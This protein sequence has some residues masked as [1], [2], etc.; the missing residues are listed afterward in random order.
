MKDSTLM[1]VPGVW[2]E[3]ESSK[4]NQFGYG[5]Y[6]LIILLD[7]DDVK[8]PYSMYFKN[9]SNASKVFINGELMAE[10][11]RLTDKASEFIPDNQPFQILL[12]DVN[13]K[14]E[15]IIQVANYID[16]RNGGIEGSIL[17]GSYSTLIRELVLVYSLQIIMA[18]V[19]L[20]HGIYSMIVYFMYK[21]RIEV[22]F[23]ALAFFSM[24]IATIAD[25]EKLLYFIL[26]FITYKWWSIITILSYILASLFLVLTFKNVIANSKLIWGFVVICLSYATSIF[27]MPLETTLLNMRLFLLIIFLFPAIVISFTSVKL[28]LS[29]KQGTIFLFLLMLSIGSSSIWGI[30]KNTE[31][32]SI[33]RYPYFSLEIILAVLFFAVYWFQQFFRVSEDNRRFALEME[34]IDKRKDEFL[35][36]TSHELR[37][38][39]HGIIMI[40]QSIVEDGNK[41]L[42]QDTKTSLQLLITVAKRLS[43]LL[44]ELVDLSNIKEKRVRL[45][46]KSVNLA[47]VVAGVL[48]IHRFM[49]E[50]KKIEF[51]HA[52]PEHFPNVRAD[53]NRLTQ[54][55][56]NLLHNALK[57]TEE[58]LIIVSAEVR[59][60]EAVITVK[61][62][63][64]GMDEETLETI[65]QRYEQG[66]TNKAAVAEGLGLGLSI[67]KE[68]V[69]L[70]GG[71]ISVQ[72]KINGGSSFSFTIPLAN[73]KE[74]DSK[75]QTVNPAL[76]YGIASEEVAVATQNEGKA[77]VLVV[78]DDF[79]NLKIMRQ[80]LSEMYD[81][82]TS[83]N[84]KE[85][86]SFLNKGNWDL[87]ITDV[88]M[89]N[90][91][92]Y[93][94]SHKIREHYSITELP[95]LLLTA[96]S[97]PEDVQAGF[98]AGAN[99]YITKPVDKM[100][101]LI[102]V[103]ALTSL[104]N[105]IEERIIMES[106]WL[107]AQIEPHFLYNTLNT[108]AAL[109]DIDSS[110][111][112]ALLHEFGNYLR[113]SF[114]GRN[115]NKLV[116]IQDELE[117]VR[118]Y[119]YIEKERFGSRLKVEWEIKK[120][121]NVQIPPLA[122]Q[123]LVENAI[124]H[125]V[126]K[127]PQGGTVR[128]EAIEE[129]DVVKVSIIDDGVGIAEEKL[130]LLLMN[131][132]E[133]LR[134]IGLVNTDKRLKQLF[135][136]GLDISSSSEGTH[137]T[138]LLP[139]GIQ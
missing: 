41:H 92:G 51:I 65:F 96:R 44:N 106:A 57:F 88:M 73:E 124:K 54:I 85:A 8:Q 84:G 47:S 42:D 121:L 110:K 77:R 107:Q 102:R 33:P 20:L 63:G 80:L 50:G 6:R 71:T 103:Q 87:V 132:K 95:I 127:R 38:P 72:S 122:I 22:L 25:D 105:S 24:T 56:F 90:M 30:L 117:L 37:N 136:R 109:S 115:L 100:E 126:L 76:T 131:K 36:Q 46:W 104:K 12:D 16:P 40:G 3:R 10:Q 125:G 48:D 70:H 133:H 21:R 39:L 18:V 137:V 4:G 68:L 74:D 120:E 83:S 34:Q 14:I 101:L 112:T 98:L 82:Y 138:F 17:L 26:P 35:V 62:D 114:N 19:L 128:I 13:G 66:G 45:E 97:Q 5:T 2:E 116:P 69:E 89:P 32:I 27:L 28:V 78:D 55:L 94:L 118:S 75:E 9:L 130:R 113:A 119:V 53:E 64:I 134:G 7:E 108:I 81:V 59:K 79:V 43:A 61:D 60:G 58:G 93:E 135:G 67:C 99:D 129:L 31:W 1:T 52:I 86:L 91:S 49:K 15:I 23:L 123:T 11:G 111:M 29:G 139:K